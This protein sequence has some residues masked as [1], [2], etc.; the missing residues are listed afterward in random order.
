MSLV[1][2]AAS[3]LGVFLLSLLV[4]SV[5]VFGVCA[6]LPGDTAQVI[7][8][9]NASP[10]A[11]AALRRQLGFDRPLPVRYVEWLGGL[12][13]GHPG[14][15]WISGAPVAE[16]IG[17]RLAVTG[18][19]VV[20]A[21]VLAT[22]VAVPVGMYAAVKRRRWQGL[23]V[24]VV[25]Q[26]GMAVPAFFAG[27]L[28][29]L[30]FAVGLRW[31]PA[32][33]YVALA[34][35]PAEWARHLVLPVVALALVQGSVLTRYVRSATVEVVGE[36]YFRTARAV[37]WRMLPALLRHGVR[38]TSIQVITVLGLQLATTLVG[39]IV[40]ESVF[41]L[42]GLGQLLLSAVSQRDLIIV[43]DIVMILVAV[44]LVINALVDL[45]YV[46][47]DPRLRVRAEDAE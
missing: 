34:E 41:A 9:Q 40:V 15:S 21:M 13:T 6:A 17:P 47:I 30:A 16:L 22:V 37:G 29:V 32:N 2:R 8:G 19:L 1:R 43:M 7:L 35:N 4:A 23:V 12:L 44:V 26:A 36:D 42:P 46:A 10:D 11:V 28:L 27:I 5:V 25:S 33:G 38:N 3:R 31:L 39:A 24:S 14:T 18:W 20:G 45:L